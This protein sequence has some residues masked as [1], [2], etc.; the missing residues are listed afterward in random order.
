MVAI[1]EEGGVGEAIRRPS[2]EQRRFPAVGAEADEPYAS[3]NQQA[4]DSANWAANRL[5]RSSAW[6]E[7]RSRPSDGVWVRL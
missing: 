4:C 3:R 7:R 5:G 2:R 1:G 6:A